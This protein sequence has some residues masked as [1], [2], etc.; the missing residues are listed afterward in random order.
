MGA[1]NGDGPGIVST[2]S[3]R[4]S[5]KSTSGAPSSWSRWR[6]SSRT[7]NREHLFNDHWGEQAHFDADNALEIRMVSQGVVP[8]NLIRAHRNT[9]DLTGR[10]N[11]VDFESGKRPRD[12]DTAP[13]LSRWTCRPRD[14]TRRDRA[15]RTT[16]GFFDWLGTDSLG[17]R[18]HSAVPRN[19]RCDRTPWLDCEEKSATIAPAVCF[20]QACSAI[21]WPGRR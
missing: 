4:R 14:A 18:F 11:V 2:W 3:S 19:T 10:A 9:G 7:V 8:Q 20:E 17:Q 12:R 5:W 15:E 6:S 1:T 13:F 16:D 21:P